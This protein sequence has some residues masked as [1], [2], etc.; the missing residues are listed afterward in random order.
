MY[1][2]IHHYY[3]YT[4]IFLVYFQNTL[5][6]FQI[7]LVPL[8]THYVPFNFS[9][10]SSETVLELPHGFK[11]IHKYFTQY[12]NNNKYNFKWTFSSQTIELNNIYCIEMCQRNGMFTQFNQQCH[13]IFGL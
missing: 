12:V 4:H 3:S 5:C 11:Q 9:N 7:L 1:V 13:T 10:R 2:Q 6:P 8:K